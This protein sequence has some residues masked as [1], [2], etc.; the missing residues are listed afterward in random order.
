M[1]AGGIVA[2]IAGAAVTSPKL[3]TSAKTN[4]IPKIFFFNFFSFNCFCF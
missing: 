3:A 2:A 1:A 4:R